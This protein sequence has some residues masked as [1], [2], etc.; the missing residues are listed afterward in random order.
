M[1]QQDSPRQQVSGQTDPLALP[2]ESAA[3]GQDEEGKEAAADRAEE[4]RLPSRYSLRERK[5]VVP[6]NRFKAD[7]ILTEEDFDQECDDVARRRK[8]RKVRTE[9]EDSD[10][11]YSCQYSK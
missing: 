1:E 3:R 5:P 8:K 2:A 11:L 7:Y 4:S 10:F 9:S 6:Y